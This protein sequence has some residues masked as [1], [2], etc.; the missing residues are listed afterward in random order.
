MP[1]YA[2]ISAKVR[3]YECR[4]TRVLVPRYV[5][6]YKCIRYESI[7]VRGTRVLVSGKSRSTR[8]LVLGYEGNRV[9]GLRALVS[10]VRVY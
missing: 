3:G 9:W 5:S 7:N 1:G 10:R 6:G 2:G 8:V 4:G